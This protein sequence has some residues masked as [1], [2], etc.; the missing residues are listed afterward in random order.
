MTPPVR[1]VPVV[2]VAGKGS[3]STSGDL[4][5]LKDHSRADSLRQDLGLIDDHGL[6]ATAPVTVN[7]LPSWGLGLTNGR[8]HLILACH[9]AV[10]PMEAIRL[11]RLH[12]KRAL[13]TA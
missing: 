12:D 9:S 10:P 6:S 8:S 13:C 4:Y 3:G 7:G 5:L 1:L 11:A 2:F